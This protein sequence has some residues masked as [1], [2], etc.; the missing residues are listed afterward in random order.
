[1]QGV[2]FADSDIIP[3]AS[4]WLGIMHHNK[5]A[6]ENAKEEVKR[7]LRLLDTHLQTC[8]FLV[9]ERVTLANITVVC[10]LLWL[11]KQVLE[12]SFP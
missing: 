12:P 10:T 1:V 3:P 9:G 8:T 5:Q 7:I 4:T 11:Y 6:S 2:S